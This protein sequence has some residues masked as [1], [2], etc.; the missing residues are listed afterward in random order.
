MA[1]KAEL[2]KTYDAPRRNITQTPFLTAAAMLPVV[3]FCSMG[4]RHLPGAQQQVR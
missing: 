1:E 3:E 4:T 2:L